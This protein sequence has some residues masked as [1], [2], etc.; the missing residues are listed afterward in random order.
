MESL[1]LKDIH[2][3]PA[4]GFWP[5]APG[6]LLL[7]GLLVLIAVAV[8]YGLRRREQRRALTAAAL[9]LQDIRRRA[10]QHDPLQTLAE[11]SAWLRRVAL[12][13]AARQDIAALR[14]ADWLAYLDQNLPDHP[15]SQGVGQCLADAQYRRQAPEHLDWPALFDLCARWLKQQKPRQPVT[16]RR[17]LFSKRS[18]A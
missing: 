13:T 18:A 16:V 12:S 3:P 8:V 10:D 7:G 1:P 14:G 17:T 9:I 2:L 6:W 11:L 5:P 4:V 15:F